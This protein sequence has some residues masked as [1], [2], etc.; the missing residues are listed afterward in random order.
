MT[1]CAIWCNLKVLYSLKQNFSFFRPWSYCSALNIS[2][3]PGSIFYQSWGIP[4][5]HPV[6]YLC[7]VL[8]NTKA[9]W[10]GWLSCFNRLLLIITTTSW[11]DSGTQST[12][13]KPQS[14]KCAHCHTVWWRKSER[15]FWRRHLYPV[16]C[17]KRVMKVR[18]LLC[19]YLFIYCHL[20]VALAVCFRSH[21]FWSFTSTCS[22]VPCLSAAGPT[23][24]ND[25]AK[26]GLGPAY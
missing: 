17:S 6:Y 1:L 18:D 7:M 5:G 25:R 4:V 10:Y 20:L 21:S 22:A 15:S 2:G 8:L 12:A 19:I 16:C 26:L 23:E 24:A 11:P 14:Q 13:W 3:E 9:T